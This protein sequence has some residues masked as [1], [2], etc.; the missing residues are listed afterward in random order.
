[1]NHQ[2]I[3]KKLEESLEIENDLMRNYLQVAE[4]IHDNETLKDRLQNFAEGNAKR[5]QQLKDELK[6]LK[7]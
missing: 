2:Q 4:K 7:H 5:T 3:A 6:T 1:M